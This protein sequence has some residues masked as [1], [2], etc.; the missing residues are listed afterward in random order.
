[1]TEREFAIDVVRS[2]QEAGYEALWAGGCVRDQLL[3]LEPKDYDVAT[4]ALPDEVCKLF[5]RTIA[6]GKAFGVIEV[7]GPRV[8]GVTLKIQVA[9]FRS[10]VSYTDGRR[11]DRVVF[12]S[13]LEDALRRDFT[14]NGMFFDPIHDRLI[15][16]VGGQ[17]DLR[18]NVL[19]AIG[20][21]L[22]RFEED[23]LRLLRAVRFATRFQMKI[24][25]ATE[26]AIRDMHSQVSVV[27]AERILEEL[28]KILVD[29]AR[30]FGL[31]LMAD[32]GLI[33]PVL[34]ELLPLPGF[35]LPSFG[36]TDSDLWNQTLHILRELAPNPTFPVAFAVLFLF[37]GIPVT[38]PDG[39]EN[40]NYPKTSARMAAEAAMRLRCSNSEKDRIEWLVGKQNVLE[41]ARSLR[42]SKLKGILA[43]RGIQELLELTRAKAR[44]KHSSPDSVNFCEQKLQQ[45]TEEDLNPPALISGND[46]QQMG[47]K[48][49]PLFKQLLDK[50]REEQLEGNIAN[51]EEA[52]SLVKKMLDANFGSST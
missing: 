21:P 15:D 20:N 36:P 2:L 29:P 8:D 11:P 42:V 10:D 39:E 14:I 4:S 3:G 35:H 27:S 38:T 9:T 13:A 5:R 24:D 41:D 6:V 47:L 16:Y 43:H 12:S 31:R 49:S 22:V 46:L 40:S 26:T 48:P 18:G 37:V 19:R 52:R 1:M 34:P 50:V 51:R 17:E 45:W 30:V 33:K 28:R 23:K 25:P 7:L 32:F 44:A